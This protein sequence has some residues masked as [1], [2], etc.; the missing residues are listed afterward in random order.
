MN[1]NAPQIQDRWGKN[2]PLDNYIYYD[3][4]DWSEI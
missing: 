4:H 3:C 2:M 1:K